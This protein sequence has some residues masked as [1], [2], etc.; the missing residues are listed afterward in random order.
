M[1]QFHLDAVRQGIKLTNYIE[2]HLFETVNVY[3]L[4][5]V[6][7]HNKRVHIISEPPDQ[8]LYPG[9]DKVSVSVWNLSS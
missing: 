8:L 6:K 7:V 2:I 4:S 1:V 9:S 3:E 5:R